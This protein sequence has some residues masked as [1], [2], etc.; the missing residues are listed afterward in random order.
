MS[1]STYIYKF[2]MNYEKSRNLPDPIFHEEISS[3]GKSWW[4]KRFELNLN[5][6]VWDF[7]SKFYRWLSVLGGD[8]WSFL[9]QRQSKLDLIFLYVF[10]LELDNT[11]LMESGVFMFMLCLLSQ[12]QGATEHM[13]IWLFYCAYKCQQKAINCS[14]SRSGLKVYQI[15][16]TFW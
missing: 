10:Y 11:K 3:W 7:C 5:L 8:G 16:Q 15:Q 13:W 2:I 4:F 9:F 14:W 6:G 1:S 12:S